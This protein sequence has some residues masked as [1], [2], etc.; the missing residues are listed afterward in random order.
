MLPCGTPQTYGKTDDAHWN[1]RHS[2]L[3]RG[4]QFLKGRAVAQGTGLD[5]GDLT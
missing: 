1:P 4:R 5:V 3:H 2:S